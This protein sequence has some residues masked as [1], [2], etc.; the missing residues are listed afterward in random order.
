LRD[1]VRN[2]KNVTGYGGIDEELQGIEEL[3]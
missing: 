3:V 1:L 2:M